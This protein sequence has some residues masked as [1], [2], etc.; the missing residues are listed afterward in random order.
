MTSPDNAPIATPETPNDSSEAQEF[1]VQQL[2]APV[3]REHNEPHDGL[4]PIPVWMGMAFGALLFWGGMYMASNAG[5]YRPDVYD[6]PNPK[7]PVYRP[8]IIP[9]DEA[10][11]KKLGE[12]IYANCLACHQQTGE[13]TPNQFPPLNKSEWVDGD[14]AS[15]ARLTRILI[16]GLSGEITVRGNKFNGAMPAWGGQ[17]KDYQIAAVLTFVRSNWGNKAGPVFPKDVTAARLAVGA[18][19]SAMTAAELEKVPVEQ[20]DAGGSEVGKK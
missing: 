15:T 18:R 6:R 11:L 16:Y 12:R 17:L 3:I 7:P 4:E 13:G 2:H 9:A 20:V 1:S 10:G 5:D 19:S 8:E 14:K